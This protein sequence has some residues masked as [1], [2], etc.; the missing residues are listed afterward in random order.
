MPSR[1]GE[2]PKSIQPLDHLRSPKIFWA[3]ATSRSARSRSDSARATEILNHLK[4]K[5]AFV[6][7]MGQEPWLRHVMV[8][9]YDETA[10]QMIESN[11]FL[12]VCR[13]R[14]IPASRPFL[15]MERVLE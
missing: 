12:E 13:G 2:E 11:K 14:N 4:P 8:L 6:Y 1:K 7:A 5:E 3:R 15:R 10:P 9:Q